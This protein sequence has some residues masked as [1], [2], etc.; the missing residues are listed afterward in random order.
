MAGWLAGWLTFHR[1]AGVAEE[2]FELGAGKFRGLG[3]ANPLGRGRVLP[4]G[5]DRAFAFGGHIQKQSPVCRRNEEKPGS[6]W[7]GLPVSAG[8]GPVHLFSPHPRNYNRQVPKAVSQS[9]LCG[10]V[11]EAG[12]HLVAQR[13]KRGRDS[14]RFQYVRLN[15][16][17]LIFFYFCTH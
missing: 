16:R 2:E 1:S 4:L 9:E 14:L 7:R 6:P 5:R 13:S 12:V 10:T 3:A 8:S 11:A 15:V 17:K